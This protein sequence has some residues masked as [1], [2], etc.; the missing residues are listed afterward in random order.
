MPDRVA[1][2]NACRAVSATEGGSQTA[3]AA[4]LEVQGREQRQDQAEARAQT[5][6]MSQRFAQHDSLFTAKGPPVL[7]A[8]ASD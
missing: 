7:P 4:G 1:S 3:V 6:E 2:K 5:Q 8:T